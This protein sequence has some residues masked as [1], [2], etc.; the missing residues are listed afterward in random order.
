MQADNIHGELTAGAT[1]QGSLNNNTARMAGALHE[2]FGGTTDYN[3]LENKPSI[4]GV[5]LEGNVDGYD[6]G[7]L[8]TV[9]YSTNE[10]N[11]FIKWIDGKEIFRKVIMATGLNPRPSDWTTIANI[12]NVDTIVSIKAVGRHT[13]TNYTYMPPYITAAYDHTNN[14]V[15]YY[16]DQMNSSGS[17]T[18]YIIIEYTKA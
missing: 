13:I 10:Y 3:E 12:P 8:P 17:I 2:G 5:T 15:K 6:I 16:F 18:L 11:T 9:N 14:N 1:L 7:I 4:N